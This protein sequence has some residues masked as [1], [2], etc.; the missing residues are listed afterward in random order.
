M[1]YEAPELTLVLPAIAT[2]QNFLAGKSSR[3]P[4]VETAQPGENNEPNLG[5]CDWE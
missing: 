1:K 4:I 3:H 5:Y 2:I